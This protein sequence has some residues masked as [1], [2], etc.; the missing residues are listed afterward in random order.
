[1]RRKISTWLAVALLASSAVS[2]LAADKITAAEA[3]DY[4]GKQA[5]VC[6]VVASTRYAA[7]TRGRP[8]FLNLDEPYPNQIFTAVIWGSDRSKFGEP[9]KAYANKRVCVTERLG[10]IRERRRSSSGV[11][12]RSA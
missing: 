8:T 5:T 11:R 9:E 6:G 7:S 10:A 3:K 2:L 4:V 12:T 1:M